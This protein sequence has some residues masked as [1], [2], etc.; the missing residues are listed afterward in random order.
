[1]H[2]TAQPPFK[3]RRALE[4]DSRRDTLRQRARLQQRSGRVFTSIRRRRLDHEHGRFDLDG[5]NECIERR[6]S[7]RLV[8]RQRR[9]T[10]SR[11]FGWQ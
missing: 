1:M 7:E 9:D 11:R 8:G 4:G 3:M 6:S 10:V 5:R 2:A